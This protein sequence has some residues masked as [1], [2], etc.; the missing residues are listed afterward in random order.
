MSPEFKFFLK[1]SKSIS[2]SKKVVIEGIASG[3]T[4][5]VDGERMS[6]EVLVQFMEAIKR[7]SLPLTDN[8]KRGEILAEIGTVVDAKVLDDTNNSLWIKCE[9]DQDHPTTPV[10]IRKLE[11]GKRFAFS[12]EGIV[13]K[14]QE[15]FSETAGTYIREFLSIIPKAISITSEPAYSP[16]FINVVS[17][18]YRK[19][20]L[21]ESDQ[22]RIND[23]YITQGTTMQKDVNTEP[24]KQDESVITETVAEPV[25]E[26]SQQEEQATQ[27]PNQEVEKSAQINPLEEQVKALTAQVKSLTDIV[28]GKTAKEVEKSAGTA[29]TKLDAILSK[30]Q[31]VEKVQKSI[32]GDMENLKGLPLQKKSVATIPTRENTTGV[33]PTDTFQEAYIK[34]MTNKNGLQ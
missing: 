12:I 23:L 29:E 22:E 8:H 10:L 1:V 7:T 20:D 14:I 30:L 2:K 15:I 33:L 18:A 4:E 5:D 11:E 16:S 9:L 25:E 21:T 31:E 24:A 32:H 34:L 13:E 26:A 3:T 28:S 6:R 17:K 27:T 19:K